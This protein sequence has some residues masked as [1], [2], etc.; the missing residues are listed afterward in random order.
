M[1]L[2][3]AENITTTTTSKPFDELLNALQPGYQ[4]NLDLNLNRPQQFFPNSTVV[5]FSN[6]T[7]AA[8]GAGERR[9]IGG[10]PLNQAAQNQIMRTIGGAYTGIGGPGR[11][12]MPQFQTPQQPWQQQPGMPQPGNMGPGSGGAPWIGS[13]D[14]MNPQQRQRA[15]ETGNIPN[16]QPQFAGG[17]PGAGPQPGTFG[18]QQGGTWGG[19][20]GKPAQL[21][22]SP[23]PPQ[24]G[25][26][27]SGPAQP[28]QAFGG[29]SGMNPYLQNVTQS[30][31]NRIAPQVNSAFARG[32]RLGSNQQYDTLSQSVAD[33]VAPFAFQN[34]ENERGRQQQAAFGA[35][36]LAQTD[37]FDIG[38]L[39]QIGSQREAKAGQQLADSQARFNFGQQEPSNRVNN[40]LQQLMGQSGQSGTSTQPTFENP[41]L[42]ALGGALGGASLGSSIFDGSG[43]ATGLGALAGGLFGL[44]G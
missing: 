2:H 5:P 15:M 43:L 22:Q 20:S 34:Y 44:F 21:P 8:L 41:G 6:Q 19:V 32:G 40:Y 36:A 29:M 30:M 23:L 27:P 26:Q 31:T 18:G 25:Y 9:A 38:Q 35:P 42:N 17:Q 13:L 39:G 3:M 7:Q 37:Y 4:A 24:S 33:A 11:M 14:Q 28:Q 16:A 10:N 1:E 12:G